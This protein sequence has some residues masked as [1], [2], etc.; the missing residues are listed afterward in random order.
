MFANCSLGG[1]AFAMPDV[2]KTLVYVGVS[3][4]TIPIPYPNIS[5]TPMALPPTA[6][7]KHLIMMMPAHNLSTTVPMTNGDNLGIL[8]GAS[9]STVMGPARGVKGSMKVFT[10][11]T[12]ITRMLDSTMHNSTNAPG[13]M[14]L[15]PSQVKVLVLS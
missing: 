6:N 15:A 10:G 4:S 9:S 5:T 12:P 1:M 13:G 2:C 8:G 7:L 3:V 14:N 11:G